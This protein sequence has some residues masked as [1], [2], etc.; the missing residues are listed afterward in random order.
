MAKTRKEKEDIV[1]VVV[2]KF[3]NA[4]AASFSNVSGFTMDQANA[5]R[6]KA[7]EMNSEVFITKK[8]LLALA[9]KEAGFE[10][11]DPNDFAGSILT[12]VSYGDEVSSAKLLME[13]SKTNDSVELVAGVL[14]GKGL[15]AAEVNQ[16]ALLPSKEQ[17]LGQL[18]GTL[19]APVSGFVRVLA[20][21]IRGLVTVLG[22]IKDQKT[23]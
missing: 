1:A 17:L 16:L 11:I 19:N 2:E 20:G 18:V 13:F 3:R 9:S 5:L 22:A 23:A 6:D 8:T 12:A 10:G 21:N 7:R 15:S 14:E 4:K